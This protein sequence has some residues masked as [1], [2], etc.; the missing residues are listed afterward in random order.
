MRSKTVPTLMSTVVGMVF[1]G[2]L[3]ETISVRYLASSCCL[4]YA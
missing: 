1:T 3:L 2:Q 4:A